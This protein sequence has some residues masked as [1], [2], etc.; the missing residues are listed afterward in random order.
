MHELSPTFAMLSETP[1]GRN[2]GSRTASL[3]ALALQRTAELDDDECYVNSVLF[4]H[5]LQCRG[6]NASDFRPTV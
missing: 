6:L 3:T 2:T 5:H 4:E 1:D